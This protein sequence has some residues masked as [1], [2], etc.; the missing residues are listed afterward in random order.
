MRKPYF[1]L[2]VLLGLL[3]VTSAA[4]AA[5]GAPRLTTLAGAEEFPGPGDP[6]GS[7]FARITLNPGQ[8]TV[9]WEISFS[10][11]AT[12]LTGAHIH[13]APAGVAGPVVVPLSAGFGCTNA[14][15]DLIGAIISSPE[16]YY[17]NVHNAEFPAGALR[18]QL[19][20]PGLSD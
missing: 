4:L 3:L 18:G 6:D 15:K 9:C 7:G 5:G 11:I 10:G 20:N 1:L 8:G 14:D 16:Q 13:S 17:V 2:I 19:S 12:P